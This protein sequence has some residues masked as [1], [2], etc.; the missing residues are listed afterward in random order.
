MANPSKQKGTGGE[1]ELLGIL[2]PWLPRLVRN[3]ASCI[4]DLT[5]P[6]LPELDGAAPHG[7]APMSVLATRPDRGRWLLAVEADVFGWLASYVQTEVPIDIEVKRFKKFAHHSI[8]E[9]KF[10]RRA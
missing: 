1:T 3:P 9:E 2:Q 7:L 5:S 4:V 8:Y 6:A 10:G